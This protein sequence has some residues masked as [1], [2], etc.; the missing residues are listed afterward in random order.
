HARNLGGK[1]LSDK[2]ETARTP[3]AWQC[4][5]RHRWKASYDNVINKESWCPTCAKAGMSDVKRKWWR[6]RRAET[7]RK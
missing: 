4:E 6:Q 2:Y 5:A 3:L 7:R 1:L